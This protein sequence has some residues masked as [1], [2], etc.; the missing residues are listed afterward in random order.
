MASADLPTLPDFLAGETPQTVSA[1]SSL[2]D[3]ITDV[4]M[5][6]RPSAGA[7]DE[8]I[9][10]DT[11]DQ[12]EAVAKWLLEQGHVVP[13]APPAQTIIKDAQSFAAQL[14]LAL[15]TIRLLRVAYSPI[16]TPES[17][18]MERWLNDYVDGRNHGPVGKPMLWPSNLAGLCEQLREWGFQPTASRPA[19]VARRPNKPTV[20]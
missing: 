11:R 14:S 20:N 12:A 5:P 4:L 18:G 17:K 7:C 2:A 10:Q 13:G 8:E 3:L 15:L 1:P 19:F 6:G 9:D 16:K